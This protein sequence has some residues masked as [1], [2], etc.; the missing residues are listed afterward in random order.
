M[1]GEY[2]R[3]CPKIDNENKSQLK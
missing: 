1:S 2:C 3:K